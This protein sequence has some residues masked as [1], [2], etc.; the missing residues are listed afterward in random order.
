MMW[1][2]VKQAKQNRNVSVEDHAKPDNCRWRNPHNLEL[3]MMLEEMA[4]L[5]VKMTINLRH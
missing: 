2:I 1:F 3:M 4:D 5:L